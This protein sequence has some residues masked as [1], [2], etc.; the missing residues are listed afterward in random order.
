M[1]TGTSMAIRQV[2]QHVNKP[3][4]QPAYDITL[5]NNTSKLRKKRLLCMALN[6]KI[7][8]YSFAILRSV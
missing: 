5:L 6:P 1:Q 8:G 2:H 7:E 3:T 4:E